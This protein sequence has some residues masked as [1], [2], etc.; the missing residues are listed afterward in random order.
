MELNRPIFAWSAYKIDIVTWVYIS[1]MVE[2]DS[3]SENILKC[4]WLKYELT[5]VRA[6][7]TCKILH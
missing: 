3:C 6:L 5:Q 1:P 4:Y 7:W 2:D